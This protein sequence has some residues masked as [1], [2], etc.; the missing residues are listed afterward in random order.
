MTHSAALERLA[1]VGF[2]HA[3]RP[4]PTAM[5][6][7]L[8]VDLGA[9]DVAHCSYRGQLLLLSVVLAAVQVQ[10]VSGPREV[11]LISE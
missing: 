1:D 2:W 6:Y 8:H 11:Y 9:S 5:W 3:E 7:G 10:R 4:L